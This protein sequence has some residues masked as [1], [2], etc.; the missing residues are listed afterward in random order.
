VCVCVCVCVCEYVC[1]YMSSL[2]LLA[3]ALVRVAYRSVGAL[4]VVTPLKRVLLSP[5]ITINHLLFLTYQ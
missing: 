2:R 3:V 5:S 1:V 4:V